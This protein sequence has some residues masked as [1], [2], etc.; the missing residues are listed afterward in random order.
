MDKDDVPTETAPSSIW[1][2]ATGAVRARWAA[3]AVERYP[4]MAR[5]VMTRVA[6]WQAGERPFPAQ[7]LD[8]A[9]QL[10]D[11][12]VRRLDEMSRSPRPAARKA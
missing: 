1:P 8:V 9:R 11:A 3:Q 5:I 10:Y 4:H 2:H 6:A 12:S 7:V